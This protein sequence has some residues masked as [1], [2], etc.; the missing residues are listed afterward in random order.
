MAGDEKIL[1]LIA[2]AEAFTPLS[3]LG[4]P[5]ARELDLA[6]LLIHQLADALEATLPV[7]DDWEYRY[8]ELYEH[9]MYTYGPD[10]GGWFATIEA[11]RAARVEDSDVIVRRLRPGPVEILPEPVEE[12]PRG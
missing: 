10:D 8:A 3:V 12:V 7:G 2:E 11:A 9:D 1:A 6:I 4:K 5:I